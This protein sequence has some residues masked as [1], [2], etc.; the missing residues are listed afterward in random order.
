MGPLLTTSLLCRHPPRLF[1][2]QLYGSLSWQQA[3]G[4][5]LAERPLRHQI[6]AYRLVVYVW[7]FHLQR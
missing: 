1:A 4:V 3:W 2:Q 7:L 5:E 6:T